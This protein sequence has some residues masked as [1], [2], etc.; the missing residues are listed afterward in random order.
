MKRKIQNQVFISYYNFKISN[1]FYFK[2]FS[3]EKIDEI[4]Q[5][6]DPEKQARPRE[7]V[8]FR[9]RVWDWRWIGQ[10]I[11]W[12]HWKAETLINGESKGIFRSAKNE[13]TAQRV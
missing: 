11:D 7:N 4:D 1:F 12:S 13:Q 9:F 3:S 6:Q 10:E 5:R 8:G 2:N